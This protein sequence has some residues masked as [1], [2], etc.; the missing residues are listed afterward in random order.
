MS[1]IG[2][3]IAFLQARPIPQERIADESVLGN[4]SGSQGMAAAS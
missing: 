1:A 2:W 3:L 4:R